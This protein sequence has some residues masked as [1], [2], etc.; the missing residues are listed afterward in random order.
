M[1]RNLI[2]KVS[3]K[4]NNTVDQVWKAV[5]SRE[6]VE[7]YMLGSQQLSDW[8]KGSSIVWKKDLNG[9][10]FEDK[11]QILE[12][13]PP[14]DSEVHALLSGLWQTRCAGKLPDSFGYP[15]RERQRNDPR[16]EIR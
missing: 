9:R 1:A 12:I 11:G 8:Q 7:K 5:V 4:I 15:E 2:A 14:K 13:A 3:I 6:I 10:K 16:I